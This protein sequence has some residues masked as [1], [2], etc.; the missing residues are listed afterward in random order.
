MIE[1]IAGLSPY[2]PN[3][4]CTCLDLYVLVCVYVIQ[5]FCTVCSVCLDLLVDSKCIIF[6]MIFFSLTPEQNHLSPSTSL[7]LILQTP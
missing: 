6:L 5:M 1:Y 7:K 3:E 4:Q 2:M